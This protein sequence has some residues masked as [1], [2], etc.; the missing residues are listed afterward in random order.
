MDKDEL[1]E[2]ELKFDLDAWRMEL[3]KL[4]M[5]R[6]IASKKLLRKDLTMPLISLVL[7][8]LGLTILYVSQTT[9]SYFIRDSSYYALLT[10]SL[11]LG[12][13]GLSYVLT[14]VLLLNKSD[15]LQA[16]I[17][18]ID[19]EKLK[20]ELGN[21]FFANLIKMNFGHI[22]KY[23]S[24]THSQAKKSFFLACTAA[25]IGFIIVIMGITLMYIGKIA[26]AYLTTG[27]GVISEFI[28]AVF[29]YLYN[30]TVLKMSLY[31]QKLVVTQNITLALKI[32]DTMD[33]EAKDK[34]QYLLVDRLT[35]DIN[36]YLSK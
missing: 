26:P 2:E 25:I 32:T 16:E 22:D 27:A 28:A 14:T 13:Y 19:N 29:Y 36:Q 35:A 24:Q 12:T 33:K 3:E 6:K 5:E 8:L 23:Y 21:D 15:R 30:K 18:D 20:S 10:S 17:L 7:G 9:K 31:H 34:A 1:A 4:Q 11:V